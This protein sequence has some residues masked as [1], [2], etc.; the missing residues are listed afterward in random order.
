MLFWLGVTGAIMSVWW[1]NVLW[2]CGGNTLRAS[3]YRHPTILPL[4]RP[5]IMLALLVYTEQTRMMTP[6]CVILDSLLGFHVILYNLT[7]LAADLP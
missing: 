1:E 3:F 6:S 4:K 5:L 7:A 2:A